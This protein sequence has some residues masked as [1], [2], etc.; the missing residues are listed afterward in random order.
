[1]SPFLDSCLCCSNRFSRFE[2][3]DGGTLVGRGGGGFLFFF[4]SLKTSF[5]GWM[6]GCAAFS[7]LALS[8]IRHH[9]RR[10]T[11]VAPD[12]RHNSTLTMS[13]N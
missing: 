3:K 2:C 12:L 4:F 7:F 1:M 9:M 13:L 6:P 5:S 11:S 8:G 10:M